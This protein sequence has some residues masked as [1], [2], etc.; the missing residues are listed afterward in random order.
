MRV[1]SAIDNEVM[2]GGGSGNIEGGNGPDNGFTGAISPDWDVI[3][4]GFTGV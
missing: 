1:T 4:N 2:I 3:N